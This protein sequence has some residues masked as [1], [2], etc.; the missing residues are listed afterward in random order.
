M[1]LNGNSGSWSGLGQLVVI[2]SAGGGRVVLNSGDG[3]INNYTGGTRVLSGTLEVAD[4]QGLP[5]T[6]V[7]NV[8]GPETVVLSAHAGTLFGSNLAG[9]ADIVSNL[10]VDGIAAPTGEQRSGV[11]IPTLQLAWAWSQWQA[12]RRRS[13]SLRRSLW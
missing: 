8:A 13:R 2:D 9:P 12:A 6:G 10:V 3:I 7:L 4:A 1:T 11:L 5:G